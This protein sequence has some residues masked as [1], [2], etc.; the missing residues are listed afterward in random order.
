MTVGRSW[1]VMLSGS[2]ACVELI[3]AHISCETNFSEL[4]FHVERGDHCCATVALA[5]HLL[6]LVWVRPM[7]DD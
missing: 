7:C 2:V 4:H 3:P 6:S 5:L 1:K